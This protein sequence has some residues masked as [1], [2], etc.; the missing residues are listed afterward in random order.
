MTTAFTQLPGSCD[1]ATV[2][3]SSLVQDG[4]LVEPIPLEALAGHA[5]GNFISFG[6]ALK[7]DQHIATYHLV[8]ARNSSQGRPSGRCNFVT[9]GQ[10][11]PGEVKLVTM[12][13]DS[14]HSCL[15]LACNEED[16]ATKH[17]ILL[18]SG[19]TWI[20]RLADSH[21]TYD[22]LGRLAVHIQRLPLAPRNSL[23]ARLIAACV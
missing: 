22:L 2:E 4:T 11:F 17:L 1:S 16:K 19:L 15:E 21:W 10:I 7:H 23:L 5:S 8:S 14:I 3:A 20:S 6:Y 18:Q 12:G 9:S 13:Q